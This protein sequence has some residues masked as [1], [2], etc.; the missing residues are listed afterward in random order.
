V[1]D[2]FGI[3]KRG[4]LA[5]IIVA[6]ILLIDQIIKIWVKTHMTL[7]EQI[8]IFSWFK[9]VFIENNG[10][11][12]GMEIG[13]KLVL[14]LFRVVAVSVLGYYIARQVKQ[15]A[16]YGYIVCLSLIM[17][18]AAGNI[19]D[20]M[21]YGLIFNASSEFYTSYF[22]PFGTGY[23]PFLMGKVVDMFY[24]PLIVTTWP[25]W[26]PMFGGQPYVFFSPI[27]NFADAAISVSV[28]LVLL[29]YRKEISEI[30]LKKETKSAD[31]A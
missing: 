13:S 31:E 12:Y 23:A 11:A 6:A 22:V 5:T 18:G 3:V 24:F 17:A 30:T 19:F 8:E 10:M 21:F 25:D 16:R 7:H 28:V 9:I 1:R 4:W 27:F 29:F 20:S 26:V 14:S 15:Q 2:N